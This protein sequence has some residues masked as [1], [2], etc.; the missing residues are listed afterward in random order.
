MSDKIEMFYV[1]GVMCSELGYTKHEVQSLKLESSY[2]KE[3][4]ASLQR[5]LAEEREAHASLARHHAEIEQERDKL[6]ALVHEKDLA[7]D[8]IMNSASGWV[9]GASDA[10]QFAKTANYIYGDCEKALA[11]TPD[12]LRAFIPKEKVKAAIEFAGCFLRARKAGAVSCNPAT[13]WD[14]MAKKA[15]DDYQSTQT[16]KGFGGEEIMADQQQRIGVLQ[17]KLEFFEQEL[18]RFKECFNEVCDQRDRVKEERDKLKYVV[19]LL[20]N[21]TDNILSKVA[22]YFTLHSSLN[23]GSLKESICA[24]GKIKDAVQ[25]DNLPR[26][27]SE[28]EIEAFIQAIKL[29]L[30]MA[31]GWAATHPVG[32]N[33][34]YCDDVERLLSAYTKAEKE[35]V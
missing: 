32:S 14:E 4:N 22:E 2:L 29:I 27:V 13:P 9:D 20:L 23:L 15:M 35:G 26:F 34:K 33:Q 30:P 8:S 7:L 17:R 25:A 28:S 16:E 10:S 1:N 11:L 19:N 5:Q 12:T 18:A 3:E 31:K 6:R 21:A 24:Y